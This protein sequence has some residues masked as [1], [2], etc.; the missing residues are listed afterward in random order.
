MNF[1]PQKF[2]G[3]IDLFA[4]LL[5]GAVLTFFLKDSLWQLL[6]YKPGS[7][8]VFIFLIVSYL[9]G[10]FNLLIGAA[11]LDE[12]VYD[13]VKAATFAEQVTCLANGKELSPSWARLLA[14][15]FVKKKYGP[16]GPSGGQDQGILS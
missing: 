13:P 9:L 12:R 1:E 4:V 3:V 2:I 15:I 11:A 6:G 16:A 7:Y 10:H 14:K 5:P 8:E